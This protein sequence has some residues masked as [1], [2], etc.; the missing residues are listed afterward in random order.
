M[1]LKDEAE[2]QQYM[3]KTLQEL[4][5]DIPTDASYEDIEN[6]SAELALKTKTVGFKLDERGLY[7][8]SRIIKSG[9]KETANVLYA[10][11]RWGK[12]KK[13]PK[14]FLAERVFV[15]PDKIYLDRQ[16]S[17]GIELFIGHTNGPRGPQSNLTYYEFVTQPRI[18]FD[19]LV[20]QDAIEERH[21]PEIWLHAQENGFGALRSQGF[22][23][24]DITAWDKVES[25]A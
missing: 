12:T 14:S 4:G 6:V 22:G 18:G 25:H 19:V 17:D 10:G 2:I 15:S 24:F 16:E 8:E 13:G 23:R 21:W 9:L 1:G 20:T 11:D 3:V 7:L 5:V